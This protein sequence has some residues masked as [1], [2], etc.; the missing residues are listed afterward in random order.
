MRGFLFGIVMCCLGT[1]ISASPIRYMVAAIDVDIQFERIRNDST[2]GDVDRTSRVYADL[3]STYHRMGSVIGET[4]GLL[5]DFSQAPGR[6]PNNYN[7]TCVSGFLCEASFANLLFDPVLWNDDRV[8]RADPQQY[9]PNGL[10]TLMSNWYFDPD[11]GTGSL[12]VF[13]DGGVYGGAFFEGNSYSWGNP[14]ATFLFTGLERVE[15]VPNPLPAP[16][17]LFGTA[18]IPLLAMRRRRNRA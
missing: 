3:L 16:V 14:T 9:A 6:G 1:S 18:L 7:A 13:D 4:G 12:T 5:V 17:I 2:G 11:E 15:L 8:D 10:E